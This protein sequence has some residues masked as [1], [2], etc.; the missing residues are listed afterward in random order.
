MLA[1][2]SSDDRLMDCAPREFQGISVRIE[3]VSIIS[4][5]VITHHISYVPNGILTSCLAQ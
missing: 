1:T 4:R 3:D 2:D 5:Q